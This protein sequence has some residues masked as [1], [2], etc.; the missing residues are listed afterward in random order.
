LPWPDSRQGK[1][2]KT[3]HPKA[4]PK[5]QVLKAI[6]DAKNLPGSSPVQYF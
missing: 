2:E 4:K 1:K 5:P 3:V 6:E